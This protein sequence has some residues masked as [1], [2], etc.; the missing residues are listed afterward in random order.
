MQTGAGVAF[1][2]S[3]GKKCKQTIETPS[4]FSQKKLKACLNWK[5]FESEIKDR[6]QDWKKSHYSLISESIQSNVVLDLKSS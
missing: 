1:F 4:F 6:K 3:S 2:N 5:P